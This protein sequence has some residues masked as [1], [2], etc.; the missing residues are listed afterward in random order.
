MLFVP[1]SQM[2]DA[3]HSSFSYL[4]QCI[5]LIPNIKITITGISISGGVRDQTLDSFKSC[6]LPLD[7]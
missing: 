6:G 3:T 2:T 4:A 5:T 7:H 1:V